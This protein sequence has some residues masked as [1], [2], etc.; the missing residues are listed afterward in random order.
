[1][2][3]DMA[4]CCVKVYTLERVLR[5]K[6]ESRTGVTFLDDVMQVRGLVSMHVWMFLKFVGVDTRE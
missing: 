3:E 6:K 4:G 5:L 1:M 2:I